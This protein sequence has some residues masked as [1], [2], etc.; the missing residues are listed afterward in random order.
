LLKRWQ[1]CT[2]GGALPAKLDLKLMKTV[3]RIPGYLSVLFVLLLLALAPAARATTYFS[4]GPTGDPTVTTSWTNGAG[5]NPANFTTAGD[6]FVVLGVS[7]YTM[8]AAWS[9]AGNLQTDS[10]GTLAMSTSATAFD[11]SVN[12]LTNNGTFKGPTAANCKLNITNSLANGGSFTLGNSGFS[13]NIIFTGNSTWTGSGDI[14]GPKTSVTV[15]SGKTLDISNLSTGIKFRSGGSQTFIVN[16]TLLCGTTTINGNACPNATFVLG[17]SGTLITANVNGITNGIGTLGTITNYVNTSSLNGITLPSTANYV[18]NGAGAQSTLGLPA[19]VA[20]FTNANTGGVLALSSSVAVTGTAAVN[21]GATLNFNGNS[22]TDSGGASKFIVASGGGLQITDANGINASGASGN[23]QTTTRTF[24]TAGNYTYSGTGAQATGSGLPV[25]INTFTDA[26][27]GGTVTLA[28]LT[29]ISSVVLVSGA[30]LSLP[31]GT[32][33]SITLVIGG[34]FQASGTWGNTGSGATHIDATDFAGTGQL[35]ALA[36]STP[37]ISTAAGGAWSTGATWIGGVAPTSGQDVVIATTGSSNVYLDGINTVNSLI[38]NAG[39]QFSLSTSAGVNESLTINGNLAN[40]GS[41]MR[42]GGTPGT[43]NTIIF[44]GAPSLWTGSGNLTTN[45]ISVTVNAG[46]TLDISGL[47]T[48]MSFV[49]ATLSFTVNG[50][51]I[52]GTQVITGGGTSTTFTLA[53]GATLVTANVNGITNDITCTIYN[54]TKAGS[55]ALS[56]T[57]NYV[58]NGTA[59]QS[60]LGLPV[61]VNAL[62][63]NNTAAAVQLSANETVNGTLTVSA[64]STLDFNSHTIATPNAPALSGALMM[65]VSKSG[66]LFTG[67]K[68]TQSAGTLTYGG[69]LTVTASGDALANGD[70]I[71]LFANTG[72]GYSGWFSSVSLPTL[73]S[74]I[75]WDTNKLA[76]TGVLDIYPFTTATLTLSTPTNTAAVMTAAKLANHTSSSRGTPVLLSTPA[77]S[78]PS[79]GSASVT[80]GALT[81]TPTAGYSGNDSFTATFRDSHGWQTI[82]VNVTVGNGTGGSPNVVYGPTQVGPNFVV[83]FAGIPGTVYTVETNAAASG[84]GWGKEVNVTAPTDNSAGFG[85]GVFQISDPVGVGSLFYRTVWPSY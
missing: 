6:T 56:T 43:A 42:A 73:A 22:V 16:G 84:T 38:I 54:F 44:A 34:A 18:F 75:S 48:G 17:A 5:A 39:A 60:T 10:G 70:S 81:Y 63:V 12:A 24:D 15:N 25:T 46:K 29:T 80:A 77:P 74:G 50:T 59:N 2:P 9:V 62:T 21:A 31:A 27:T 64:G 85:I 82:T 19:T 40:N 23:V 32:S 47:T 79:H 41:F 76:T 1:R 14:S 51:L 72:S 20:N 13:L 7:T 55:P 33:T 57:A 35:L 61:T 49:A 66:G 4:N 8:A 3:S 30:K 69:S 37:V 53:S 65:E 45:K 58:F 68:L 78:T 28:Q 67:S 36:T 52:A 71:T 26:N 11:L 83:R